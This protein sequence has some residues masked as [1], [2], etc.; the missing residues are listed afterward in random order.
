MRCAPRI[1]AKTLAHLFA[2]NMLPDMTR[3]PMLPS[4]IR[5]SRKNSQTVSCERYASMLAVYRFDSHGSNQQFKPDVA[6]ASRILN[7]TPGQYERRVYKTKL[8]SRVIAKFPKITATSGN[9]LRGIGC[10]PN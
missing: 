7:A 1:D 4:L 8:T 5:R 9:R 3:P 6:H 2:A 10:H